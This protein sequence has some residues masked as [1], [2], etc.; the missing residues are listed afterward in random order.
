MTAKFTVLGNTTLT[1]SSAS[2]TVSSIP[3][4]YKDLVLVCS[5]Q[6]TVGNGS[7]LIQINGDT[8][9]NYNWVRMFGSAQSSSTSNDTK[10]AIGNFGASA[11][12]SLVQFS[13]YSATDKHKSILSR[14]NDANY[15]VSAYANRWASTSAITSFVVYPAGN[16]FTSGSTF[17]LLGVN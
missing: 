8:G 16:A 3:G 17:R 13:D 11:S 2:V 5:M 1:T 4:G 15:L 12:N 6:N 10:G 14:T 7:F 9:S